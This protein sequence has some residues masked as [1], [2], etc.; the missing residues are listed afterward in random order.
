MSRT[1]DISNS[2]FEQINLTYK[3]VV[4]TGLPTKGKPSETTVLKLYFLLF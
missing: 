2:E 1:F 4:S 3:V